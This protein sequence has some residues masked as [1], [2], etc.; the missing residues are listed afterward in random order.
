MAHA[1]DALWPAQDGDQAENSLSVTLLRLRKMNANADLFLRSDG[2]LQLDATKVWSD[3]APREAHLDSLLATAA[4]T[5]SEAARL[6]YI[7]RLFDLYRGDCLFGTED[8]WAL[9]RAAHYRG[10]VT[11]ATQQLLQNALES[12]HVGA[13]QRL[14]A[15]AHS[16]GLD[17]ERLLNAVHP[18]L[19]ATPGCVQ[20]QHQLS[21]LGLRQRA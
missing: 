18:S 2:W 20:L 8:D 21:L 5:T 7:T 14:M 10:R 3:A 16:R 4:K 6:I 17:V 13:A 1:A 12:Q 15:E 9:T 11:L 19:R